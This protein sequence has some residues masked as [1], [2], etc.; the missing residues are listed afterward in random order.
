MK[1]SFGEGEFSVRTNKKFSI[2]VESKSPLILFQFWNWLKYSFGSVV[3]PYVWA[4][5]SIE[6][7]W[8]CEG[9][10]TEF[11]VVVA[12]FRKKTYN[13]TRIKCKYRKTNFAVGFKIPFFEDYDS[14]N[15][16][17]TWLSKSVFLF[18]PDVENHSWK[19][20][21]YCTS[22]LRMKFIV[23]VIYV[24]WVSV[25]WVITSPNNQES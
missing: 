2:S 22:L 3:S 12:T 19:D 17:P 13:S 9:T 8:K 4:I 15:I 20:W 14:I 1:T 6:K 10:G 5:Q 7:P 24:S 11:L 16:A 25:P 18:S 21:S 23:N